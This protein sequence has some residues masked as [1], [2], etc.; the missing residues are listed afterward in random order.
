MA[1]IGIAR[2]VIAVYREN[3]GKASYSGGIRFGKAVRVEIK[4]NYEDVSDYGDINDTEEEEEFSYADISITT[5]E[6]PQEAESILFG[7]SAEGEIISR[8]GDRAGYVGFGIRT[9]H[10][11]SGNVKYLAI[12]LHK[13]K[14]KEAG[15]QQDTKGDSLTYQTPV[16]EGKAEPDIEG[17]W[18]TK[19]LF[20]T[21]EKA[22]SWIDMIAGMESEE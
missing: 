15:Q 8:E 3:N 22:D 6:T 20:D 9:R 7:H 12:W 18:R 11:K 19:K 1:F 17:K 16:A 4:P 2:P 21:A 14:L 13:T 10:V 5:D